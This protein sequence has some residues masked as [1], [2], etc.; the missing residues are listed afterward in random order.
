M[1]PR[2]PRYY[3]ALTFACLS[4][5]IFNRNNQT[6]NNRLG[7]RKPGRIH[8]VTMRSTLTFICTFLSISPTLAVPALQDATT[9]LTQLAKRYGLLLPPRTI[10]FSVFTWSLQLFLRGFV[11]HIQT[12]P[13]RFR[14]AA[15]LWASVPR[16]IR[17][18]VRSSYLPLATAVNFTNAAT[19]MLYCWTALAGW[20]TTRC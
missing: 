4:P 19:A 1:S 5:S 2:H 3:K 11:R 10:S 9:P 17:R 13:P 6:R 8:L 16:W 14:A 18:K 20:C 15:I 7:K 12:D